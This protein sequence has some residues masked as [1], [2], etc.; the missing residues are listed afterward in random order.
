MKQRYA[1][2]VI[3]AGV[4]L[5]GCSTNGAAI[6]PSVSQGNLNNDKLQ[7]SVGTANIAFDGA[8]GLNV[9]T[10]FRQPNGLSAVLLDAPTI[11]GPGGFVVTANAPSLDAGTNHISGSVQVSTS[12]T[13]PPNTFGFAGGA[14]KYGFAPYNSD[15][16]G[17]P[18]PNGPALYAEPFYSA[19][20]VPIAGG[21]PAYPFFNDGTFVAGFPG[22]SQGFSAFETPVVTGQYSLSVIVPIANGPTRT[23]STAA[24]LSSVA[25]LPALGTPV[26]T[27]DTTGGGTA[28]VAVPADPRILETL[29]YIAD[30]SS[31]L[32]FTIGPLTGT[33]SLG[34]T[35]PDNLGACIGQGCQNGPN[36]AQSLA[37]GDGYIVYAIA[38]DYPAFE[39]SPPGSTSQVPVI[40]GAGGQADISISPVLSAT[41]ARIHHTRVRDHGHIVIH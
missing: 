8:V 28:T 24:T 27:S 20:A 31:G 3:L 30:T 33:G 41:Y 39:A 2:G 17:D 14:F 12:Q 19:N 38:Y 1:I 16:A 6:N 18:Y 29:I 34:G 32:I 4:L 36:A 11:A 21:P 22:Y 5:V 7:M 15:N 37:S 10:T 25:P 40:A 26:F 23:F 13:P 9:V 35:L